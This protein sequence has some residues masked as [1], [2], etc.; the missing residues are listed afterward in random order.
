MRRGRTKVVYEKYTD[1]RQGLGEDKE[2]R[3]RHREN[4]E[5][6]E[7]GDEWNQMMMGNCRQ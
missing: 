7:R 4:L 1:V 2:N 5:L 6:D 3:S